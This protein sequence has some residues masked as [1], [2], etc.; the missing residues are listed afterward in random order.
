MQPS[1]ALVAVAALVL[2]GGLTACGSSDG[3]TPA[4]ASKADFCAT[5]S[6]LKASTAPRDV[7]DALSRVGTPKDIDSRARHGFQ[8][9][10]SKLRGL[11][12]HAKESDLRVMARGL[13]PADQA[14]VVAFLTYFTRECN[15]DLPS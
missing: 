4:D 11:P 7:A 6:R 3:S 15:A 1:K 8:V 9:L 10:I 5:F 2:T 13:K 14:D 12:A